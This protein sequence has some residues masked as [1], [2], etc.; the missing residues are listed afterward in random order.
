MPGC[1]PYLYHEVFDA[2][3]EDG[4]CIVATLGQDEE[5]LASPGGQV[6]VQLQVQIP[7]AGPSAL[8][9]WL[10]TALASAKILWATA[11]AP[12]PPSSKACRPNDPG[13]THSTEQMTNPCKLK[14][15]STQ[16][17]YTA[18]V[19]LGHDTFGVL[20]D[21]LQA[22][23]G[24]GLL[25]RLFLSRYQLPVILHMVK[26]GQVAPLQPTSR[27]CHSSHAESWLAHRLA[28]E[29]IVI[30]S[31]DRACAHEPLSSRDAALLCLLTKAN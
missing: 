31:L 29:C 26:F 2:S 10:A 14:R 7:Q 6:A 4:V 13:L 16:G 8:G 11:R 23:D 5:V 3:V 30:Q 21:V 9:F 12:P 18:L 1:N 17:D 25:C 28:D 27:A 19:E 24:V 20:T 15:H 22:V